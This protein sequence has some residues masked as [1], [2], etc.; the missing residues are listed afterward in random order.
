MAKIFTM[1]L[2]GGKGERLNPLT[3][4]RAKPA[5]PFGGKISHHRFHPEQLP[6]LRPAADRRPDPI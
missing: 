4:Q 2:A 1:V 3:E 6:E 5:V